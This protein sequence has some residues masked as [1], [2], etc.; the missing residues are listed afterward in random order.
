MLKCPPVT[1]INRFFRKTVTLNR[2]ILTETGDAWNQNSKTVSLTEEIKAEI[3]EIVAEEFANLKQG[4]VAVGD[5]YG[6][7]LPSYNLGGNHIVMVVEQDEITWNSKTWKVERV[8]NYYVGNTLFYKR[9]FLKRI[10]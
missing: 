3:Q 5:A 6:Y 2:Y 8:E 7:F 1:I 10:V 4:E 9:A